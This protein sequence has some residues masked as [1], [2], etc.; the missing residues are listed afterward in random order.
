MKKNNL[1]HALNLKIFNALAKKSFFQK[2][3]HFGAPWSGSVVLVDP[4]VLEEVLDEQICDGADD[5]PH[6]VGVRG[7]GQV[8]K[9][10]KLYF[11][12]TP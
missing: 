3:Y 12:V 9:V 10:I 7:A 4:A 5:E 11:F 6:V 8:T 2:F 1:E